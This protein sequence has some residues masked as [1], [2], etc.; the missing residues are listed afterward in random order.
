MIGDT[1]R[2]NEIVMPADVENL[3]DPERTICLVAAPR[4][5][6]EPV[7]EIEEEAE[8]VEGEEA[9][10]AEAASEGEAE[11]AEAESSED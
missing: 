2:A 7:E 11:S 9:P 10:A 8:A 5:I 4:V 3:L 1:V 6:E